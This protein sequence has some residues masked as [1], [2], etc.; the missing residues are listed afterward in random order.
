M[1]KSNRVR[2]HP[3]AALRLAV[4]SSC[5]RRAPPPPISKSQTENSGGPRCRPAPATRICRAVR[6]P[7]T[8]RSRADHPAGN[9]RAHTRHSPRP[10][11]SI[12]SCRGRPNSSAPAPPIETVAEALPSRAR[13]NDHD[14]VNAAR[15]IPNRNVKSKRDEPSPRIRN[16]GPDRQRRAGWRT[17]KLATGTARLGG[18]EMARRR[19][20]D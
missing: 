11:D 2:A 1:P 4:A 17:V 15:L 16:R 19:R 10:A 14:I 7:H 9:A 8:H 18:R 13:G 6:R 3:K 20:R 12:G 5:C